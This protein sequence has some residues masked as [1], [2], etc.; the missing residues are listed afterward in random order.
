MSAAHCTSSQ[1]AVVGDVIYQ[2]DQSRAIGF[3]VDEAPVYGATTC[4]AYGVTYGQCRFADVAVFRLYDSVTVAGGYTALSNSVKPP[5]IPSYSGETMY[6]GSSVIGAIVGEGVA[7]IGH[8]SGQK[9]GLVT[10]DCVDR[11][12]GFTSLWAFCMQR[13][14]I[15][16]LNGDSGGLV[17][18]TTACCSGGPLPRPAGISSQEDEEVSPGMFYSKTS[19]VLGS[20]GWSYFVAW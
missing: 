11:R 2:P 4:Q 10:D 14:A 9:S 19:L 3:E 6:T 7:R 16:L 12:A 15:S 1:T 13:A 17:Y 20:L 5:T 18:V 8:I